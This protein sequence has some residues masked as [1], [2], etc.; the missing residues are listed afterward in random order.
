MKN[1]TIQEHLIEYRESILEELEHWKCLNENG[2]NDPFWSDGCNMNLVRNHIIYY[3]NEI[4][5]LCGM[6]GMALPEEYYCPLPPKVDNNYMAN[7]KQKER[8]RRLM[9]MGNALTTR[10]V[11]FD[12]QQLSLF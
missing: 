12:N 11:K 5:K 1:K 8:V 10:K 7:L 3:K 6:S 2:C 9:Q 4:A